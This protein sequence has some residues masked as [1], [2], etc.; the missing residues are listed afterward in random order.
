M[1][2]NYPKYVSVAEKKASAEKKLKQLRKKYPDIQPVIIEGTAIAK[3]WW[4][5]AWNVN[6]ERYADYSNRIGRGRSYVRAGSVL[7]LKIMPGEIRSLVQGSRSNPYSVTIQI[8]GLDTGV[9]HN[10][11]DACEGRLES[12]SE[13]LAGKFPKD[14]SEIFT[15]KGKG[16]F[17]S[18]PEISFSCS[19]PDWARM[20]KHVA[21]TLYGVGARLDQN[22]GL[23][24]TLRN[25]D[26]NDLITKAVE[27]KTQKILKKSE[28]KSTRVIEDS[29]ISALFGIEIDRTD[30]P[31]ESPAE[32]K[33][34]PVKT[35]A[36]PKEIQKKKSAKAKPPVRT[37]KPSISVNKP[38]ATSKLKNENLQIPEQIIQAF[39]SPKEGLTAREIANKTG[40]DIIQVR[41]ALARM[42][43][44]GIIE[45]KERG[46]YGLVKKAKRSK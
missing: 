1:Y 2:W 40:L 16:L 5:K 29:N 8:R 31:K 19:C 22:P 33:K 43:Q 34:A 14:L 30:E 45:I 42:K 20:C 11:K 38:R 37:L 4:G 46:V 26:V 21:A 25:I 28:S 27:D 41:N 36:K 32:R 13:L 3:T 23:F 18:P 15:A 10:I 6:L 44:Q 7:D 35:E 24:F 17:P 9:W 12:L 39:S